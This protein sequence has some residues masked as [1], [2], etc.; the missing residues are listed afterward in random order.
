MTRG[1]IYMT[2]GEAAM[3]DAD[4]S[5]TSLWKHS[6]GMP[7]FVVGDREAEAHYQGKAGVTFHYVAIDPFKNASSQGFLA[8]RIKP[9]LAK[10]S[11]FDQSLYVDADSEFSTSPEPA[12]AFLERWDFLVAET[13]TRSLKDSIAGIAESKWTANWLGTPHLLYHNSGM[14]FWRRN[15]ATD[16]LFDLWSEE[17][18]RF[19]G[20]D[21]QVPLLRALLRSDA[22]Y[23]TVPYTWNCRE[24]KKAVLLHHRFGTKSARKFGGRRLRP[25]AGAV[26]HLS[27]RLSVMQTK[28]KAI[29]K[30][31]RLVRVEVAPGRFVSCLPGDVEKYRARFAAMAHK[32][33]KR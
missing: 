32:R 3:A 19:S 20:W 11:P 31:Q 9:L 13:E 25:T 30:G 12:F 26:P 24:G 21:E 14:L 27:P 2:W 15:A 5:M 18:Q 8:G 23:L 16:R 10:L 4:K 6:P 22:L 1:V 33:G 28:R 29:P 17:W 7:V